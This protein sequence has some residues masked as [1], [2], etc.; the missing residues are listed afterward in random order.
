MDVDAE[1]KLLKSRVDDLESAVKVLTGQL[2]SVQPDLIELR[3]E[4][5]RRFDAVDV[6]MQRVVQRLDSVNLQVWSL[7]DDLPDILRRAFTPREPGP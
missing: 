6:H 2:R 1:L 7:R 4:T 5:G 3:S